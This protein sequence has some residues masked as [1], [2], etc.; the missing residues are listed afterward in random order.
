MYKYFMFDIRTLYLAITRQ[1]Y[2]RY[3]YVYMSKMLTGGKFVA[4]CE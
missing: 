1:Q 4:L 2:A 3:K